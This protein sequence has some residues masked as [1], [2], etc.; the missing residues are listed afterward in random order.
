MIRRRPRSTRTDT[1]C[2]YTT[3]FRS[4]DG[5][6]GIAAKRL[7]KLGS[8]S[9]VHDVEFDANSA[10]PGDIGD[11]LGDAFGDLGAHRAAGG[12]EIAADV[13]AV[14]TGKVEPLDHTPFGEGVAVLLVQN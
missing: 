8:L 14:V 1:L 9:V 7:A 4:D 11:G 12:R 13:D 10:D 2:P 6:G 3:L 5:L